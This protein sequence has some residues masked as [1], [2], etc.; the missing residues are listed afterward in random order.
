MKGV[1]YALRGVTS[2]SALTMA[3]IGNVPL[4]GLLGYWDFRGDATYFDDKS[5]AGR[6]LAK[7]PTAGAFRFKNGILTA[8]GDAPAILTSDLKRGAGAAGNVFTAIFVYRSAKAA[9]SYLLNDPDNRGLSLYRAGASPGFFY[10]ASADGSNP[11][12]GNGPAPAGK[13]FADWVMFAIACDGQ[14]IYLSTDGAAWDAGTAV[15][16]AGIF[17][18][19]EDSVLTIGNRYTLSAGDFASAAYWSRVISSAELA[20]VFRAQQ[21]VVAEKGGVL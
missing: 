2:T 7:D 14:R 10:A 5:G 6:H 4:A 21:R 12:T 18:L 1:R 19:T 3:A 16:P 15:D 11:K 8:N 9:L 20:S 17:P 13:T